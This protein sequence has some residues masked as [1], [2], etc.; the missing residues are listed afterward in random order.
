MLCSIIQYNDSI[1]N[2]K[3]IHFGVHIFLFAVLFFVLIAVTTHGTQRPRNGC[4]L[5]KMVTNGNLVTVTG[6]L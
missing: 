4:Q 6:R 2:A 3:H 1:T 5:L